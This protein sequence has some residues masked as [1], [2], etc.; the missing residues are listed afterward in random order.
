MIEFQNLTRD[1]GG[2]TGR[3]VLD[4][5]SGGIAPGEFVV[6]LGRSG[7]G[8]STLLN[9]LGGLDRPT[10][11]HVSIAGE[12]LYE[13]T[14]RALTRLRRER[15]GFVFQH[16]NL[17]P[18]LTV[19][20]NVGLPLALARREW[21]HPARD[22]LAR[23]AIDAHA[24]DWPDTLSGGEQQRVAIARALIH[25]PELILADEPTG[26]LDIDN[27]R[28]VVDMLQALCRERGRTL[29]M[30]THSR[31][32]MG[33]ADRVLGIDHGRLVAMEPACD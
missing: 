15:I 1:Y 32:V 3:C 24:D 16:Y 28:H 12:S 17:I 2:H 22:W 13:L 7:S 30:A 6:I 23:L 10:A 25:D 18:T 20:E 9:L 5:A 14:D 11:G 31:E 29:V 19:L 33:R 21:R 8:K 26:D 4:R 27:A